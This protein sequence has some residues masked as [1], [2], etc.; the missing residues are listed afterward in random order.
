MDIFSALLILFPFMLAVLAAASYSAGFF[1]C[2]VLLRHQ[3]ECECKSR[4]AACVLCGTIVFFPFACNMS[5]VGDSAAAEIPVGA[6]MQEVRA[7]LG[8]PDDIFTYEGGAE[9]Y[10]KADL[11]GF[12]HHGFSFDEHGLMEG[13]FVP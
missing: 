12:N 3:P 13:S 9:W 8:E 4:T 5:G 7:K 10:Y 1:S 6:T 2:R 11:I